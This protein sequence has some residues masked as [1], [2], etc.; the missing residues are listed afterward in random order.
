MKLLLAALL[1]LLLSLAPQRRAWAY[2]YNGAWGLDLFGGIDTL[3]MGDVNKTLSEHG[4]SLSNGWEAGFSVDYG[5]SSNWLLTVG[6]SEIFD[7]DSFRGGV[8]SLPALSFLAGGEYVVWPGLFKGFDL[9][10]LGGIEYDM[11]DGNTSID[12]GVFDA[13]SGYQGSALRHSARRQVSWSGPPVTGGGSVPSGTAPSGDTYV[14]TNCVGETVGGQLSLKL[15]YFVTSQI[16]LALQGGYRYSHIESVT[17][18]QNGVSG[19]EAE[20]VDYSGLISRLSASYF[21]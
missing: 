10:V 3:A 17:G 12:P 19:P 4:G 21:F 6:L 2:D 18:T 9:S 14:V 13:A 5:L 16:A 15:K 7:Q 8:I 1:V 20:T 11:L